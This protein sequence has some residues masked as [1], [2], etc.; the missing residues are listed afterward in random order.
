MAH[1][2]AGQNVF[3]L[4]TKSD[5]F[6]LSPALSHKGRGSFCLFCFVSNIYPVTGRSSLCEEGRI[7]PRRWE[8]SDLRGEIRGWGRRKASRALLQKAA[9]A[10]L[11]GFF[12]R[13][14]KRGSAQKL[15]QKRDCLARPIPG[16]SPF[17]PSRSRSNSIFAIL[18][19][20]SLRS[21]GQFDGRSPP[22]LTQ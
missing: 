20:S 6:P 13:H 11:H 18:Q 9:T 15:L 21:Q 4:K 16:A 2:Y 7:S 17:R 5:T 22:Y 10:A 19:K 1:R 8:R 12:A 3:G 14:F